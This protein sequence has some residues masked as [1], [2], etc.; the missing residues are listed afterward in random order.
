MWYIGSHAGTVDDGYVGSGVAFKKAL[1]SYG[2][3]NFEREILYE[4][5]E[6]RAVEKHLL[7]TADASRDDTSYNLINGSNDNIPPPRFGA[8][9][10]MSNPVYRKRLSDAKKGRSNGREG[11]KHTEETKQKIRSSNLNNGY[12]HSDSVKEKMKE[13]A[14]RPEHIERCVNIAK[15]QKGCRWCNNGIIE[16]MTHDLPNGWA[17]G[18]LRR[19]I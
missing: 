18:R 12:R 5:T 2:K 6:F 17:Y 3:H 16:R 1:H 7:K 15:R 9:N 4:G 10:P 11:Y 8:D 19:T 14:N 13:L